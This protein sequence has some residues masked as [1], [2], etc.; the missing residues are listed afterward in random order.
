[1]GFGHVNRGPAILDDKLFVATL[2]CQLVAI[3]IRSGRERWSTKVAD[4]K[5][6]YSMTLAPLAF[7]DKV[8]IGMSGGE[9]GVRGFI[10]AYDAKTGQQSWRFWTIPGP[11]EPG[12]D[13]WRSEGWKTGGGSTWVT[14]SYDPDLNLVYWGIGNPG[15]D[16]NG[17]SRPGD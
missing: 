17:D 1:I 14:G 4:Y 10:D 15:P 2:D 3:D 12:H 16:W 5:P 9:A 11:G 13:S 6:G 7:R 8:V